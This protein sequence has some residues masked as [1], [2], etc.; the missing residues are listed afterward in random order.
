MNC[1]RYGIFASD[2]LHERFKF[3]EKLELAHFH[4]GGFHDN[5]EN[6]LLILGNLII[7][8]FRYYIFILATDVDS[9]QHISSNGYTDKPTIKKILNCSNFP[10]N[11]FKYY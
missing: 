5:A 3:V 10:Q 11:M 2:A 6:L 7:Y 9:G 1:V 8:L 4:T